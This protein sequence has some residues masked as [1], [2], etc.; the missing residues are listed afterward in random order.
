MIMDNSNGALQSQRLRT[1]RYGKRVVGVTDRA[2]QNGIDVHIEL[3]ILRK[4]T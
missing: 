4:P 3:G 2:S 1:A